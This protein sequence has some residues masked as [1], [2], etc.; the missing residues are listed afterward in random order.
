[1]TKAISADAAA[2]SARA[3]APERAPAPTNRAATTARTRANILAAASRLF[4]ERGFGAVSV[5]DIAA[6][7]GLSHP[8]VAKH[9]ASKDDL[10]LAVVDELARPN[11]AWFADLEHGVDTFPEVA[12]HNATIEGYLPLFSTLAGEATSDAH[13]AHEYF[14]ERHSGIHV[15]AAAIFREAIEAGEL[16]AAT[17]AID[18]SIRL[19]AA[20]DGLQLISL[21]L[22]GRFDL[23]LVLQAHL[24]RLRGA[25]P[26]HGLVPSSPAGPPFDAE[27]VEGGYA[28]GRARRLQIVAD[29]S[30]LFAN[31]GFHATS[32]REIAEQVGI[33]KSTLLHH[34]S[35][36]E[37]L[38]GAVIARRDATIDIRSEFAITGD[39][40]EML[41]GL[42]DSARL[43][44]RVEPGLIELY[45]VLSAEA[46]ARSHPAHDYFERRFDWAI[47]RFTAFFEAAAPVLRADLDPAFEALWLVAL[48]DGLQLQ[49]LYD[50]SAVD[51][52][53]QL[54]AHLAQLA[55]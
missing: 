25:A 7:A 8:G 33:G 43:A 53:D 24:D 52:G 51:I 46:A 23:P 1:M 55:R 32:L 12:R 50:P 27:P 41:D 16:P 38:L 54:A 36:K 14:R 30:T 13:P 9:F 20:W 34:F 49:W 42:V 17:D 5:R 21:Y 44:S 35:S 4:I 40:T 37:E 28:P 26:P 48:W 15:D 2:P 47:A 19:A 3:A 18:E 6:E 31:R 22:P 39:P 10:L 29:A 11:E 45:A